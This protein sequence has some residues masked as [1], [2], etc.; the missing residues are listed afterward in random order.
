MHLGVDRNP[1]ETPRRA[2][3]V[4]MLTL[5]CAP[6]WQCLLEGVLHDSDALLFVSGAPVF[7]AAAWDAP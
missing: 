1:F 5:C 4:F 3:A 6:E 2:G 7:A